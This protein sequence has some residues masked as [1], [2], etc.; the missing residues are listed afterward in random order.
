MHIYENLLSQIFWNRF[1]WG[2]LSSKH[3]DWGCQQAS[4]SLSLSIYFSVIFSSEIVFFY[5]FS[6]SLCLVDGP[7]FV[8]SSIYLRL[9]LFYI[10]V[11]CIPGFHETVHVNFGNSPNPAEPFIFLLLLFFQLSWVNKL[12]FLQLNVS[13]WI[14]TNNFS[15]GKS[16]FFKKKTKK[17]INFPCFKS[18][19]EQYEK[20]NFRLFF[21]LAWANIF[22]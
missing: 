1:D 20:K 12:P 6:L 21:S 19:F 14:R 17:K 16:V 11:L 18:L 7:I 15:Y 8:E 2:Y 3:F 9:K 5:F 4:L 13:E 10:H 22:T